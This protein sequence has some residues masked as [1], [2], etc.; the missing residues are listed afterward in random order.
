MPFWGYKTTNELKFL[1]QL[2]NN[3]IADVS[4]KEECFDELLDG[5]N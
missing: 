3:K 4:V 1:Q 2:L 5:Y